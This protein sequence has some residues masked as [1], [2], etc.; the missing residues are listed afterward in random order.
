MALTGLLLV[1]F[2]VQHM[3]AHMQI[4]AGRD[5]YNGYA[6]FMYGLGGIL[7]L[8][9]ATLL[10]A[11]AVHVMSAIKLSARNKEA[12]PQAYA[13]KKNQA[14]TSSALLMLQSGFT[15]LAF[16]GYHI[17]HFTVNVVHTEIKYI[18]DKAD[19]VRDVFTGYV[20]SLIH[21]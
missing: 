21:I 13:V 7:W 1:G 10:G 20:L 9:R 5:A 4:F 18:G 12:R 6:H 17:A 19:P 2:V 8:A 11:I 3:T 15:I 14:T 16:V